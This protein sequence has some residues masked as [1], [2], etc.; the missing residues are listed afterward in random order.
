MG[1]DANHLKQEKI[2]EFYNKRKEFRKGA[3]DLLASRDFAYHLTLTFIPHT[4]EMQTRGSLNKFL[5]HLNRKIFGRA[6]ERQEQYI[7][8]FAIRE[9]VLSIDVDHFHILIE[10]DDRL[11][12]FTEMLQ[13]VAKQVEILTSTI[14][15]LISPIT[16]TTVCEPQE[17]GPTKKE[18]REVTIKPR[19]F[20]PD[21]Q[22]H[23]CIDACMLQEYY[24]E[25]HEKLEQYS[26]QN[27]RKTSL[28]IEDALDSIG[29]L[30]EYDVI[31]GKQQFDPNKRYKSL[32]FAG[33][34]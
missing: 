1:V 34:R 21:K 8:G 15:A 2:M 3:I 5:Q 28:S 20:R 16:T 25:G 11:P 33:V 18:V 19:R 29:I 13:L 31:F 9:Y 4:S 7:R 26:S 6:Y 27:F 24:N 23:Y 10:H 30:N 12:E 22:R 17:F 32:N 14:G